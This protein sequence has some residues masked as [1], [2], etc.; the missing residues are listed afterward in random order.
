MTATL[1]RI[2][3]FTQNPAGGNPAGVWI[4]DS[5][6]DAR[7]MQQIAREIGYSETV[8]IAPAEGLVR[9]ARYFSPEAE[10]DFCGHATIATGVVL[11]EKSGEGRYLLQTKAGDIPLSV[12]RQ[13][14][15]YTAALTSVEPRH[16]VA[17]TALVD[18]ALS[19]LGWQPADLDPAIPP[20]LAFAG[21]W[22]LVVAVRAAETLAALD[23]DFDELKSLMLQ[24]NLTTLQLIWRESDGIIHSRNP[25][26]I[27]GIVEDPATGAA[28]A[29][30]GGYLRAAGLVLPPASLLIRQ[31]EAM[32]R[33]SQLWL[34]IPAQ[35]GMVVRGHAVPL[36]A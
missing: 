11:G 4:G 25:F 22:H 33:P 18:A 20:A 24:H 32:G 3:A 9:T 26:P 13:D 5:L 7:T 31:G 29:A 19:A 28:A 21:N 6:P 27:G 34:D 1:S 15:H 30:L 2:A 23:Y 12:Q 36:P 10:V 16:Q 17:S 35:G 8:F 14:G